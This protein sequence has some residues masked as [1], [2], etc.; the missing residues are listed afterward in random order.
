MFNILFIYFIANWRSRICFVFDNFYLF[1]SHI[2][3]FI[4]FIAICVVFDNIPYIFIRTAHWRSHIGV[5]FDNKYFCTAHWRS[6]IGVVFDNI[7]FNLYGTLAFLI[8]IIFIY[9]R[10]LA[11]IILFL[12]LLAHIGVLF[13]FFLLHIWRFIYFYFCSTL[14]SHFGVVFDTVTFTTLFSRLPS[15]AFF[16]ALPGFR[17]M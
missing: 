2:G 5:V 1:L 15:E 17:P 12:F 4:Y 10:T 8:I 13:L 3:V 14:A 16:S 6:H 7:F 11:F 9:Y